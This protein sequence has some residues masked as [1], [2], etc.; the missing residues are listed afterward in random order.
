MADEGEILVGANPFGICCPECGT[1]QAM[2]YIIGD[3]EDGNG[4]NLYVDLARD[5]METRRFREHLGIPGSAQDVA[6]ELIA[7][8]DLV[9][10]ALAAVLPEEEKAEDSPEK[11]V[12]QLITILGMHRE[13]LAN[14]RATMQHMVKGVEIARDAVTSEMEAQRLI[15]PLGQA[16]Y[17][18][19]A[20][21]T[22][23]TMVPR[24]EDKPNSILL[25][26]EARV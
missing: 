3:R 25:S 21:D 14:F 9:R 5:E 13:V 18:M 22:L 4:H 24:E 11:R 23:D 12:G 2:G 15:N 6:R 20:K 7:V 8:D 1:V 26:R 17:L 16:P 10:Q 19:M